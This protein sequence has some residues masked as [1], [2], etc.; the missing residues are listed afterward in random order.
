MKSGVYSSIYDFFEFLPNTVCH[1]PPTFPSYSPIL[2]Y[3]RYSSY[4]SDTLKFSSDIL[5]YFN[6]LIICLRLFRHTPT[7]LEKL[8]H[9]QISSSNPR[10]IPVT[11]AYTLIL[12]LCSF[13]I[14]TIFIL[15]IPLTLCYPVAVS[16]IYL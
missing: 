6:T 13:D 11:L 10:C 7:V 8:K 4:P 12:S 9:S 16:I 2:S 15:T 5:I 3:T 14:L 1:T